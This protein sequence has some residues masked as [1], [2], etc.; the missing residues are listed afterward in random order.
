MERS[1]ISHVN[2]PLQSIHA[3]REIGLTQGARLAS[4]LT[5]GE[6]ARDARDL[7]RFQV[8]NSGGR[9]SNRFR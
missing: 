8:I 7:R 1:R 4:E 3:R 5:V 2:L 6:S 9:W